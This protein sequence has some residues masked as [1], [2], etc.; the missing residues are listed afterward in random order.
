MGICLRTSAS[1]G[2]ISDAL[3]INSASEPLIFSS[4]ALIM[5]ETIFLS[6]IVLSVE[7]ISSEAPVLKTRSQR[8]SE[9]YFAD[10]CLWY[11]ASIYVLTA[12]DT[13]RA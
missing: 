3:T 13:S 11:S 1:S 5:L 2:M 10:K 4:T 6:A 8:I 7:I 12:R 9:K